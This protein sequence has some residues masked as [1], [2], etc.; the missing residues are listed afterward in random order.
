ME[1]IELTMIGNIGSHTYRREYAL[2]DKLNA[3][4]FDA[5]G[6]YYADMKK[7]RVTGSVSDLYTWHEINYRHQK[8]CMRYASND[9]VM[10]KSQIQ[11]LITRNTHGA[12]WFHS[13][14]E[15]TEG[16]LNNM[17]FHGSYKFLH[18]GTIQTALYRRHPIP[19]QAGRRFIHVMKIRDVVPVHE[20]WLKD[21]GDPAPC[22]GDRKNVYR[23]VNAFEGCG[24]VSV[25]GANEA[26]QFV[27]T[28]RLP[29]GNEHDR[30][31][32]LPRSVQRKI[33]AYM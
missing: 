12:Y 3:R 9:T 28:V 32:E 15:D 30:L 18:V 10:L 33:K 17:E 8:G 7:F 16:F 6:A 22:N 26:F 13:S 1:T 23:Y 20:A 31:W 11:Y 27:D 21:C 4:R 29:E 5:Y 24:T 2:L 19:G 25:V 14:E